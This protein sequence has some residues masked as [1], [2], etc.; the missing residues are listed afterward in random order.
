VWRSFHIAR[1]AQ[2][3]GL[4][5]ASYLAIGFGLWL[6]LQ[7]FIN[8]GVNMGALPTKGLTLPL[9]SYGRSSLIVTIAWVGILLRV[10]HEALSEGRGSASVRRAP[11]RKA[12]EDE[13]E[14]DDE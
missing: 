2:N 10:Y 4:Q 9:M 11:V 7:A 8:I 13:D 5:F 6:G 14:D 3:A 12:E 1:L